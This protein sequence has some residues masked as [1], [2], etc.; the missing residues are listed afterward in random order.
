MTISKKT[1]TLWRKVRL[2]LDLGQKEFAAKLGVGAGYVSEIES[3]KKEPSH[4]L[5]ELFRYIYQEASG[6]IST[7]LGGE[8]FITNPDNLEDPSGD[9]VGIP[10]SNGEISAGGGL[11]PCNSFDFK[12]FFHKEWLARKGNA[13]DMSMIRVSGNSM[14]PTVQHGDVA[15]INHAVNH[16]DTPGAIYAIAVDGQVSLKRLQLVNKTGEIKIISD[17]KDYDVDYVDP[18]NVNIN[19]KA[20]WVG[21]ELR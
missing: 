1:S 11:E 15:L 18:E 16:I 2:S 14:E 17:N 5:A 9:Y 20:L 8:A 6:P 12:L 13:D 7:N 19:G 10:L 21:R 3:G 4:T